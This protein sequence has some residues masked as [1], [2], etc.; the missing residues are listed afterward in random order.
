MCKYYHFYWRMKG[1]WFLLFRFVRDVGT[2]WA[3]TSDRE[4]T[5]RLCREVYEAGF[6]F[7]HHI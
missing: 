7:E 2:V 4:T 3:Q 5:L 6:I 1:D